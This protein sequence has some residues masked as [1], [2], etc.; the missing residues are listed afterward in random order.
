MSLPLLLR[1][2]SAIVGSSRLS[3]A[4]ACT[5]SI[6]SSLPLVYLSSRSYATPSDKEVDPR[7]NKQNKDKDSNSNQETPSSNQNKSKDEVEKD[8]KSKPELAPLPKSFSMDVDMPDPSNEPLS[9]TENVADSSSA[10]SR[11]GRTGAKA[12]KT[13]QSAGGVPGGGAAFAV[14]CLGG[15]G[16]LGYNYGRD[17]EDPV[18]I[19]RHKDVSS[20]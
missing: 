7:F 16:L 12:K 20:H 13:G 3:T 14:I 17:F 10:A 15:L 19:D 2:S 6:K 5:S 9:I 11:G 8:S 18:A 4:A 1:R